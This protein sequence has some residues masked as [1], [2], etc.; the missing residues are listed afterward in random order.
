MFPLPVIQAKTNPSRN[1]H[2]MKNYQ[3]ENEV[4]Y[5]ILQQKHVKI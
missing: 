5:T 3:C 4:I 1:V 2:V